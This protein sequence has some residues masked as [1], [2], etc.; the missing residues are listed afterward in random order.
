MF[1]AEQ[2]STET[3]AVHQKRRKHRSAAHLS[4]AEA[5]AEMKRRGHSYRSAALHT[6][7]S[8]Q[9]ICIV[10]NGRDTSRPVL[11]AIYNLPPRTRPEPKNTN[12]GK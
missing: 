1:N 5:K 6:G 3:S 9:W 11:E 7:H 2:P 10:L 12:G 4:P 8:Y